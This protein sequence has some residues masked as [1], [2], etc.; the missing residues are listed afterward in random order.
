MRILKTNKP[1]PVRYL[2]SGKD[3][4]SYD[5]ER[6]IWLPGRVRPIRRAAPD[7][8]GLH[9]KGEVSALAAPP[10]V[11]KGTGLLVPVHKPHVAP[12]LVIGR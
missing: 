6:L 4:G 11:R 2:K 5:V 12:K 10:P 3:N 8:A 9:K 7:L 1:I